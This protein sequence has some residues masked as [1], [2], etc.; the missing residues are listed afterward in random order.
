MWERDILTT[1]SASDAASGYLFQCRF[2]LL[3]ALR[4]QQTQP[5]LEISI[6][7]FDDVAFSQS[8]TPLELVQTKHS[9]TT[10]TMSDMATQLWKT[11]GIWTKRVID[12][13]ADLGRLKL[14]LLTTAKVSNGSAL[15]A[16][17]PSPARDVASACA[18]LEEAAT[19]SENKEI[20][21]A[22][23]LFLAQTP[24]LRLQILEM[25]EVL[26]ASANIVDVASEI[27]DSVRRACRGEHLKLFVERLEGWWFAVVI[28]ALAT[29]GG[30]LVPVA[31]IDSKI[32]DLREEFGPAKL[33]IDYA[34]ADPSEVAVSTLE[35]RPFVSQLKLVAVG[36]TGQRA[37][38]VDYFRARQQRSRWAREG[39]LRH[40][41]LS[42]Y[43]KRLTENW[44]RRWGRLEGKV[45]NEM[46]H[47]QLA[48]LGS[49][50]YAETT[51]TCVPLREVSEPFVSHGSYHI[52]SDKCEVGWHPHYSTL[53]PRKPDVDGDDEPVE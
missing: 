47:E 50:L 3:A 17:R 48:E 9:L 21:W 30:K 36:P 42:E 23:A 6:E 12:H 35:A 14:T 46:S 34:L 44:K 24:A 2:A 26:D 20:A 33:P 25:V 18:K 19:S 31:L 10:K 15:A 1:H 16:L 52:L 5:G 38:I 8:G 4:R 28:D 45:T 43:G 7:C 53:I 51:D 39:L 27:A 29:K 11:I 13:P 49:A 40:N 32:D 22:T 37:A 41:E